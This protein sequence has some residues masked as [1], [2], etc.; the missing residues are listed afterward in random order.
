MAAVNY[1]ENYQKA[2]IQKYTAGL[3]FWRLYDAPYN[4]EIK[5]VDAK[6]V[7]IPNVLV[8][9]MTDYNRDGVGTFTRNVDNQWEVKTLEHDREF[10]TL[11]DPMDIDETNMA[12]S[13]ANITRVFNDEEKIPEMDKYMASKLYEEFT[14]LGG[15]A[16][17]TAPTAANVLEL[18]DTYMSEMDEA[19]VP[20][21]NRILYV[22]PAVD[23]LL[24]NAD[25]ISRAITVNST[26]DGSIKRNVRSLDDVVIEVVSS[27]R[28]KTLYDF[29]VGAV[30]GVGAQQINMLLIHPTAVLSPQK[31]EMVS[32]DEPSA[33]TGGKYLYFERKY[34]DV[35]LLK[36]KVA[37]VK[38]NVAAI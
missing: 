36:N 12:L 31:Y 29:T 33:A 32:L 17:T 38:F 1:A 11:V 13:I 26:N 34:W 19:E 22:T 2:L 5:F 15:V 20:Q 7:K 37:G 35:F 14:T 28:M 6:T 30:A 23:T 21:E 3:R 25:K 27:A 4:A 8:K 9:G 18:F 10:R 16:D 24:K